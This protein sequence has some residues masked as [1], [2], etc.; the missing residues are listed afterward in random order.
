M[1]PRRWTCPSTCLK[2]KEQAVGLG[3]V[4]RDAKRQRRAEQI[5][6]FLPP[7]PP[8]LCISCFVAV[9]G[10]CTYTTYKNF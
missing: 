1:V 7:W 9:C 4:S 2:A 8:V 3:R 6:Q 10:G 5:A